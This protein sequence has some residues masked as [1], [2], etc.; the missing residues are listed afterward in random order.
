MLNEAARA[1]EE[2]VVAGPRE[3]DLATV[4][5]MGFPPFHGGLLRW[6]DS[7]GLHAIAEKLARIAAAP[8]V[9][10]RGPASERFVPAPSLAAMAAKVRR[11]HG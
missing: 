4:F 1:L 9:R 10:A 11:F 6:A 3:L 5:G 7:I 2:D 8:D